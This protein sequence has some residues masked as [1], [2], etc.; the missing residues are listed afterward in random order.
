MEYRTLSRPNCTVHTPGYLLY[1]T[2]LTAVFRTQTI[3]IELL[4]KYLS[5]IG[6]G[7][8]LAMKDITKLMIGFLIIMILVGYWGPLSGALGDLRT[9][10]I[11]TATLLDVKPVSLIVITGIIVF[12]W[13]HS[14]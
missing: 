3:Q 8:G 2:S 5:S 12:I 6:R 9:G 7:S 10:L 14:D 4:P 13:Y 11:Q 1:V